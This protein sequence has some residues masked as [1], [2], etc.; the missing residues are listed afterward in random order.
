MR[1][2]VILSILKMLIS[3]RVQLKIKLVSILYLEMQKHLKMVHYKPLICRKYEYG[4][5]WMVCYGHLT[6]EG[7]QLLE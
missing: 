7:W 2:V 5:M 6:I 3:C 1:V 4:K